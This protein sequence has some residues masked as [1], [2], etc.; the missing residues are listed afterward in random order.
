MRTSQANRAGSK[1]QYGV[2]V[3]LLLVFFYLAPEAM[4]SPRSVHTSSSSLSTSRALL[5][6]LTGGQSS[7]S[8]LRDVSSPTLMLG[9]AA[10]DF[11]HSF[12][13][14]PPRSV[15]VPDGTHFFVYDYW[16]LSTST[17]TTSSSSSSS[18]ASSTALTST[19]DPINYRI[20]KDFWDKVE[21]NSWEPLTFRVLR[22]VLEN[23][24]GVEGGAEYLDFGAWIGPTVLF[25]A[26]YA[27]RVW[28]LE[29]D[30][31]AAEMLIA[32]F[33]IAENAD[34]R[35]KTR[36]FHE[37][38]AEKA[39]T[40]KIQGLGQSGSRIHR[41][42]IM[43]FEDEVSGGVEWNIPCRSLPQ[44]YQEE[45]MKNLR[46]V[47]MDVEGAELSVFP[48]LGTWLREL[49]QN[50]SSTGGK[51]AFWLSL[52]R[53]YWAKPE[54]NEVCAVW[55]LFTLWKFIYN[56]QLVDVSAKFRLTASNE[57]DGDHCKVIMCS[58]YC[59]FLLSDTVLG[60]DPSVLTEKE[61]M[62]QGNKHF[63]DE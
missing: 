41:E 59:E 42:S 14:P 61:V 8:A 25:A 33:E 43:K 44:F 13:C 53:P 48:G 4:R 47:K 21:K 5:S 63:R 32:N 11:L 56:D 58:T 16:P 57:K 29:P 36:V 23:N 34:I 27:S 45:G 17:S 49:D 1:R 26:H 55:R 50:K 19:L 12:V 62:I 7:R 15:T 60:I 28:T 46:L 6:P 2:T 35:K 10:Q 39:G 20:D 3:I 31:M 9:P 24:G 52:H 30:T 37:C 40:L 38:I 51:P 54:L 22:T 18:S